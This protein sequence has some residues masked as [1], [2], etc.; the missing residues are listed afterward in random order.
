MFA[1]MC[2]IACQKH[3]PS[4]KPLFVCR[5][6]GCRVHWDC[7]SIF[8]RTAVL[9]VMGVV[10]CLARHDAS[11]SGS[12]GGVKLSGCFFAVAVYE[13]MVVVLHHSS[14]S[15][16]V[17]RLQPGIASRRRATACPSVQGGVGRRPTACAGTAARAAEWIAAAKPMVDPREVSL[18]LFIRSVRCNTSGSP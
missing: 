7:C 9:L 15:C 16:P 4:S 2:D 1:C 12:L 17:C 18:G 6:D 11:G 10:C 5:R 8:K 3:K 13:T 14:V